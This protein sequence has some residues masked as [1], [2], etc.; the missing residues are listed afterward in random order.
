MPIGPLEI[1]IILFFILLLFGAR[2]LPEMG[3]SL[4]L[5]M[6]EFKQGISNRDRDRDELDVPEDEQ[7]AAEPASSDVGATTSTRRRG[8][9]VSA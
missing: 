7:R 8:R 2:R 9:R 4:G 3:R 1:A 5:G 6:R